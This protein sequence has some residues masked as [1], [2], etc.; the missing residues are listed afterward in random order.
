MITIRSQ[1]ELLK[2]EEASRIVLETLDLVEKAV[3]PG[4]TTDELDAIAEAEIRRQGARPAFIGYRGYPKT[5]CTSVN[6]E[7]VHGIPGKRA[8]REGDVIGVD[9]GA[10]FAGYF[11]D[12]AR[13]VAVGRVP[14]ET[15]KL[16]EVTKKALGAGIAAARPGARVSDIG[17]AVEAVAIVHGYGVVRDFVGHGVGTALHEEPQVPNYGPAGRGSL[18]K[19]GMVLAIEPMFNLG[20]A[21]VSVDADGW[22]V[23]TRD[24]STSAHFEHTI[25]L[26]QSGAVILGTGSLSALRPAAVGA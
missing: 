23:R 11:G 24:R 13:T 20:R 12:A 21:E 5:L 25:A 19:A 22:T 26:E 14:A 2:L 4:V 9:C 8:L 7:V 3:A 18:L 1:S 17:A 10:V 15:A 16:L 6:D